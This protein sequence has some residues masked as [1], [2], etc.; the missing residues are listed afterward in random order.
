MAFQLIALLGNSLP[1]GDNVQVVAPQLGLRH[2]VWVEQAS[3]QFVKK[4]GLAV[5]VDAF[6]TIIA[7]AQLERRQRAALKETQRPTVKHQL[8]MKIPFFS[9]RLARL[10]F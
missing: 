2:L 1:V 10:C 4:L 6:K 8:L 9:G 3:G 7:Q 5:F